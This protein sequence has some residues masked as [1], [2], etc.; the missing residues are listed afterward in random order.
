[1]STHLFFTD[2]HA[3]H[4]HDNKRAEYLGGLIYETRPDVVIDGGDTCDLPSL[5]SYDKGTRA[6]VGRTY[7]QDIDAHNDFQDRL[8]ARARKSKRK[9]PR[10]VRLIGNHEQRIDR[11]LDANPQLQDSI[12]YKDLQLDK[13][14]DEVI[15]YEGSTPGTIQIDG[16]TYAHYFAAG[17]LGRPVGGE[18]AAYSLISKKHTT[19]TQ[20]HSHV[21]DWCM[22]NDGNGKPIL[23]LVAPC[24]IDYEVDWA[25]QV[26]KLWTAGVTIKRGVEKGVYSP[27]FITI[28]EL[29]REYGV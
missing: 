8:W 2:S 4:K 5:A 15:H 18:H 11:A 10:R 9:L 14:Y 22:K 12:G 1:M 25:G 3:H 6:A 16:I 29:E 27:Q 13:Y 21:I 28:K 7:K 20:G 26:Q 19:C 17:L 23:G 24:F